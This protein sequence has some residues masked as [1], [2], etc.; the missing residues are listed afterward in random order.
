MK[1]K[2][3]NTCTKS[4][5]TPKV[6]S[7]Q[8][9][10]GLAESR[11]NMAESRQNMPYD[12]AEVEMSRQ[13]VPE[14]ERATTRIIGGSEVTHTHTHTNTHTNA[15]AHTNASTFRPPPLP[16]EGLRVTPPLLLWTPWPLVALAPLPTPVSPTA[17]GIMQSRL[18]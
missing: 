17:E 3:K 10:V 13:Y 11:Q 15:H 2:C 14:E 5:V 12:V 7:R 9:V 16:Q 6:E 1:R 18:L 4:F 8:F